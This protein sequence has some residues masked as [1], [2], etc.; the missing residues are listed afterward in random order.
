MNNGRYQLFPDLSLKKNLVIL[1]RN[2]SKDLNLNKFVILFLLILSACSSLSKEE[3][4]K[5]NFSQRGQEDG[6]Q[7]YSGSRFEDYLQECREHGV[8]I[9]DSHTDYLQGLKLGLKDYCTYENGYRLGNRGKEQHPECQEM[10]EVFVRGY[11]KGFADFETQREREAAIKRIVIRH[12]T[13]TCNSPMDCVKD[14][15]QGNCVPESAY[16]ASIKERVYVNICR[17]W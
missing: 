8:G 10:S 12:G 1:N 5:T 7:G 17:Y 4:Q 2:T 15:V 16:V 9:A 14:G 11:K 6:R 13:K 3:C